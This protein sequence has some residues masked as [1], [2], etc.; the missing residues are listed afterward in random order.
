MGG[1]LP[2][3][4]P[5]RGTYAN[6]QLVRSDD[7]G[8]GLEYT[9]K[10]PDDLRAEIESYVLRDRR[11]NAQNLALW[12]VESYRA[13]IRNHRCDPA[14]IRRPFHMKAHDVPHV[15]QEMRRRGWVVYWRDRYMQ[16][17]YVAPA[18]AKFRR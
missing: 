10:T 7:G 11:A 8:L 13:Y 15:V 14:I 5:R 1:M 18:D 9:I 4:P 6:A 17:L 16:T 3:I 12:L 2:P